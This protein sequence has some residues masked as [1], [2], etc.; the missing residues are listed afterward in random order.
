MARWNVHGLY[1][2]EEEKPNVGSNVNE[3]SEI[4]RKDKTGKKIIR[5]PSYKKSKF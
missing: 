3:N 5:N 4:F 2:D 1:P